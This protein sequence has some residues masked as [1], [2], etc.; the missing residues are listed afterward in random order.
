LIDDLEA[1]RALPY[2]DLEKKS[3]KLVFWTILIFC[4]PKKTLEDKCLDMYS[5]KELKRT[6]AGMGDN[7]RRSLEQPDFVVAA[8]DESG[9]DRSARV[10]P[11]GELLGGHSVWCFACVQTLDERGSLGGAAANVERPR[12]EGSVLVVVQLDGAADHRVDAVL[13]RLE[14]G[15]EKAGGGRGREREGIWDLFAACR[16]AFVA[17]A[18]GRVANGIGSRGCN[19]ALG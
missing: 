17:I 3:Q 11:L 5:Q 7:A 6:L 1:P 14:V 2:S 4:L 19:E 13:E 8:S 9:K 16:C 15:G 18:N 12:H 10:D